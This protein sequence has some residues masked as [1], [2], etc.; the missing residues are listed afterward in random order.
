MLAPRLGRLPSLGTMQKDDK[1]REHGLLSSVSRLLE[2]K[3]G[4]SKPQTRSVRS[5]MHPWRQ[6]DRS[7]TFPETYVETDV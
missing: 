3:S 7:A 6:K 1:A 5:D 2:K 4:F